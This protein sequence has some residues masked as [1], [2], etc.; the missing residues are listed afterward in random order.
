MSVWLSVGN[1]SSSRE[2]EFEPVNAVLRAVGLPA[3]H[4]PAPSDGAPWSCEIGGY[5]CFYHLR[6]IAAYAAL[7]QGLPTPTMDFE[8]VSDDPVLQLYYHR[9]RVE[10]T[11]GGSGLVRRAG[12]GV[13]EREA[14]RPGR[15]GAPFAHLMQPMAEFGYYL[16]APL[17]EVIVS[18]LPMS[19]WDE[20]IG[21]GSSSALQQECAELARCLQLPADVSLEALHQFRLRA[22]ELVN[23]SG[24]ERF[25]LECFVCKALMTGAELSI[26]SG[27]ALSFG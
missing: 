14:L 27:C 20:P 18:Y 21:I 10:P 2:E 24:W 6:R 7:D 17:S 25:S 9:F 16:P 3:H 15:S 1:G 19:E 11:P 5:G 13:Q 26:R 4:E 12:D 8:E 22:D 23:E